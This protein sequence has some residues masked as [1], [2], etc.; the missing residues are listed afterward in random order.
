VKQIGREEEMNNKQ[1]EVG[2][3]ANSCIHTTVSDD[4]FEEFMEVKALKNAE[5]VA[6]Y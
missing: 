1:V 3:A 2:N 4:V 5:A 6:E